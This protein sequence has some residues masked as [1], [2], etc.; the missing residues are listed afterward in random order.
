MSERSR[1]EER[2]D[3]LTSLGLLA[4]P[5]RRLIFGTEEPNPLIPYIRSQFQQDLVDFRQQA[6][7]YC[8]P[9]KHDFGVEL[10]TILRESKRLADLLA[11]IQNPELREAARQKFSQYLSRV[12]AAIRMVPC[13]DP[14]VVLPAESPLKTYFR[15]RA[16][17]VGATT[18]LDLFDPYLA[19]DVFHRYLRDIGDNTF[20]TVVTSEKAMVTPQGRRAVQSRDQIVAVSELLALERPTTYRFYV[21]SQQHDRHLRADDLILHLGGSVKDASRN[22]PYTISTLDAT[23]SNHSVLDSLISSVTEWFGFYV[24]THRRA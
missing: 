21:T 4:D 1:V 20:I 18:R 19:A 15:L 8:R 12:Q 9:G 7:N 13:D 14:G 10:D 22:D 24:T 17:C 23:N 11:D 6:T 2:D 5:V 3:L 16:V